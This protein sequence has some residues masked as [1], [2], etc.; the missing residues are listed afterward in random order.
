MALMSGGLVLAAFGPLFAAWPGVA[1]P[2]VLPKLTMLA[3]A[4][5]V[6]SL[7]A[8]RSAPESKG[9]TPDLLRPLA[10]CLAASALACLFSGDRIVGFLGE[11]SQRGYGFL[12][13]ALC[14]AA[15]ALAQS[16]GELGARRVLSF[17][18][19]AGAVLAAIGMLQTAGLDP[20]LNDIGSLAYGRVGSWVG[21]PIGLGCALAMLLPLQMRL[22]LDGED[23]G[24]R[25]IGWAC[26]A[27]GTLGLVFTWSRGAWLAAAVGAGC[28]LY[29]TERRPGLKSRWASIAAA[30]L[31]AGALLLALRFVR[32]T[33]D[34]DLGR[35]E[36]WRTA[37]NMFAAHPVFGIGPDAF[38][39]MLGRYKTPGFVRVYGEAGAQAHAHNDFLQ[40]LAT[41][42]IVGFG[43]YVLLLSAAWRRLQNALRD[44][45]TR[46]GAAAA[47]AGLT[48][49][50]VVAKFNPLPLDALAL[51]AVLLGLL[52]PRGGRARGVSLAASGL[53]AAGL[54]LSFW[55]LAADRHCM[56]GFRAQHE[57]RLDDARA[58]YAAAAA[59]N[60]AEA[61][62]GYWLVGLLRS[63]A[64]EETDPARR[65][66]L[67]EESVSAARVMERWNPL[68]P[69][70]LH[71]LGGSLTALA[72][73]GG[74]ESAAEAAPILER[75]VRADWS[76]RSMIK[77]RMAAAALRGDRGAYE[78]CVARL[79]RLGAP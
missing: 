20:V 27:L 53:G 67:L 2:Y 50:F 76:D 61:R 70:A 41:M 65:R 48:A 69:R 15:A 25:R 35:L 45:G 75:G 66:K 24:T 1:S 52:D 5:F 19:V 72:A 62:Y 17:G 22:A 68:D 13:L 11:Y 4:A 64:R 39:L 59:V 60:P 43:A 47:G 57:G 21:S 36:V 7:G 40:V 74:K 32:P 44:E 49:A 34:S 58:S 26:L 63:Q 73:E 33:G 78:D 8:L 14:A 42:G 46:A 38:S 30:I 6:A 79:A 55:M 51:A 16:A 29:W 31:A 23:P 37:W 56:T 28:Y 10:V 71:A 77:T 54:L 9:G 12:T 3:F 18:A